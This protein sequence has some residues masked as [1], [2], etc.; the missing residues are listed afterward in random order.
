MDSRP[1]RVALAQI[2]PG[3]A[4]FAPALTR[5]LAFVE[6]AIDAGAGLIVFPEL[7]LTGDDVSPGA[8]GG[9]LSAQDPALQPFLSLSRN[10]DIVVGLKECDPAALL[11]YNSAFYYSAGR[12]AHRQR[13]LFLLDYAVWNEARYLEPGVELGTVAS[14]AGRLALLL[15]NDLWHPAAPYLAALQGAELLIVP[16]NSARGTLADSLDIAATWEQMNR[17]YAAMLGF[18]LVFVNRVGAMARPGGNFRYWGGS[19]IVAP[20]GRL[21]VK[22]P[23]DDEALLVGELDV[24][25][26]AE[27]RSRAPLIRDSRPG[28][29]AGE[30]ARLVREQT[31]L[32]HEQEESV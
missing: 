20:D 8:P 12:L 17:A 13:K 26:V 14:P 21:V 31:L 2:D 23:Y 27:Q 10:I 25:A 16:A 15:C 28:F 32:A 30:F 4:G 19:E 1:L 24:A 3:S 9:S 18:Y 5:H 7:S 6:Q 11:C 22:A 29:F